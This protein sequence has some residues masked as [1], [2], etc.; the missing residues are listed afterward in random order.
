MIFEL[1]KGKI[2]KN[3]NILRVYG[4]NT[5]FVGL[6]GFVNCLFL[7]FFNL[8]FYYQTSMKARL[9]FFVCM[10]LFYINWRKPVQ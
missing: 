1:L 10:K 4:L 5:A 2:S 8:G 6:A 9:A 3:Y 7:F